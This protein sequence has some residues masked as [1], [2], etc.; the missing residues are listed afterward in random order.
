MSSAV[1]PLPSKLIIVDTQDEALKIA[2]SLN[3]VDI[4]LDARVTDKDEAVKIISEKLPYK[5]SEDQGCAATIVLPE[6]QAAFD[7]AV[8]ITQKH[9]IVMTVSVVPPPH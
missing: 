3:C 8:K 5:D 4:L 9:G 1:I 7:Y 6:A 2:K